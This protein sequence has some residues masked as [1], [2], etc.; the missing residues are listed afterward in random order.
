MRTATTS[1]IPRRQTAAAPVVGYRS[2]GYRLVGLAIASLV[3]A[4]FWGALLAQT[5]KWLN[6]PLSM[7]TIEITFAAIA[8]F[9]AAVCAPIILRDRS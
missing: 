7:L 2:R 8:L 9:L 3:P 1:A 4:L 5:A 6:A